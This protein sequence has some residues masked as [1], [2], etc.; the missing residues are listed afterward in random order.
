M[1]ELMKFEFEREKCKGIISESIWAELLAE[2]EVFAETMLEVNEDIISFTG[3]KSGDA[4]KLL[5]DIF[6]DFKKKYPKTKLTCN[7]YVME[8]EADYEVAI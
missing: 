3:Y 1:S 6:K 7:V 8:R 4:D 2:A 5:K